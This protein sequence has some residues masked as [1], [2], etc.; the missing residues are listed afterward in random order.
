[1][2]SGRQNYHNLPEEV[3]EED[4]SPAEATLE[5]QAKKSFKYVSVAAGC[6]LVSTVILLFSG[7]WVSISILLP[8]VTLYQSS[9]GSGGDRLSVLDHTAL[10]KRGFNVGLLAFGNTECGKL[11]KTIGRAEEGQDYKCTPPLKEASA[12]ITVNKNVKHQ[13]ILGFGGAFTESAAINFYKLP[14][15]VQSK[16]VDLYFG[17]GGIGYTLG[18]VHINSCDF[19]LASY[20]FNEIEGDYTMQYFD[21]EVTHDEAA[22]MP[23]IRLAM[24]AAS[25]Q[26]TPLRLLASPWSPPKWMKKP[27]KGHKNM[28]GSATPS[29]LLDDAKVKYAWALYISKWIEA[30]N[31]KGVPVWAI[32]P[33]NEPEFA[34]PWEACTYNASYEGDWIYNY[35]GPTMRANHPDTLILAF[36]HNKD[37]LLAWAK[38]V[39][40]GDENDY[41]D[42]MA[43]HWYAGNNDRLMDGT[44]GYNNVNATHHYKPNKVLLA[45]EGCSC[46]NVKID[47]WLR[48]ERLAHDVMFDLQ[49]HAQ[50][51]IDWNLLVDYQGGPNHL[52]NMCD[53][54]L[55]ALEDFS[56]VYVQPKYFYMGHLSKF[57]P[58]GS[59]RISSSVVGKY[60]YN[61]N[62][63]PNVRAGMELGAYPCEQSTRQMWKMNSNHVL[64]LAKL[65]KDSEATDGYMA[66]LC[67]AGGDVDRPYL[68]VVICSKGAAT[69][70]KLVR[71]QSIG[72]WVD[73]ATGLCVSLADGV[74]EGGALLEL[75]PCTVS[76]MTS[77]AVSGVPTPKDF[78]QLYLD[79]TTGEV[80][81][82]TSTGGQLCLT[83]GWPFL[84]AVAFQDTSAK[85]VVVA[86]NEASVDTEIVLSDSDKGDVWFGIQ[87]RSMQTLVY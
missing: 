3:I 50:G 67:V 71:Q 72:L 62:M 12:R 5:K 37:H 44:Y 66:R 34:A 43:F 81:I 78:Q 40:G 6:C 28:T 59:V 84:T 60:N 61:L 68:R 45:T 17:E 38:T 79:S 54:P 42:G 16:V 2:G 11:M 27:V 30:Y 75:A 76:S 25:R 63:D 64:E 65:A 49:N 18:R 82:N 52:G 74:R 87:A 32:T 9:M 39:M 57:V 7:A 26:Q 46:P 31:S 55:V 77:S 70:L 4:V 8:P 53:A 56:D 1:M 41:V 10:K 33:Q 83:V 29:G 15:E 19:S 48:A 23:L 35:L 13:T 47:D 51:W 21:M 86:L 14:K 69:P 58:P 36:D 24:D 85:T 73:E 80:K 22:M 20:S